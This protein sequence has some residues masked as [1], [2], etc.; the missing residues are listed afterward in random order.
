[1][2]LRRS[3]TTNRTK[4]K[5]GRLCARFN[6]DRLAFMMVAAFGICLLMISI[7]FQLGYKIGENSQIIRGLEMA[8]ALGLILLGVNRLRN[9][10]K[11][12]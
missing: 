2:P 12:V 6:L 7:A 5:L 9:L 4:G 8:I 3:S 10:K 11:K 1:M